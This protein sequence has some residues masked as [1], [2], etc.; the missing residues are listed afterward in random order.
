MKIIRAT[1]YHDGELETTTTILIYGEYEKN[2]ELWAEDRAYMW[3]QKEAVNMEGWDYKWEEITDKDEQVNL[4][5][6]RSAEIIKERKML[7]EEEQEILKYV[8]DN[9]M[10]TKNN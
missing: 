10:N 8:S 3:A 2:W 7:I 6:Q 1:L 5:G 9:L 4:L